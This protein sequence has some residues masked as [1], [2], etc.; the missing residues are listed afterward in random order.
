M[1]VRVKVEIG[2]PLYRGRLVD[3]GDRDPIWVAFRYERLPM[4]CY[5][6]GK[7]NHDKRDC[8]GKS[9][10][11][12][13][14]RSEESQYRAWLKAD[15]RKMKKTQVIEGHNKDNEDVARNQDS[16]DMEISVM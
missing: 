15:P 1:R 13:N 11:R 12:G 16:F 6:Y 5:K 9:K 8:Q 4:F 10:S 14:Q 2:Q 3:L 7:L